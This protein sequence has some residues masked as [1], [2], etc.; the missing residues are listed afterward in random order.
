MPVVAFVVGDSEG[1]G[2]VFGIDDRLHDPRPSG[3]RSATARS[4]IT[5]AIAQLPYLIWTARIIVCSQAFTLP[6]GGYVA[7]HPDLTGIVL[8]IDGERP[9]IGVPAYVAL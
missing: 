3:V 2:S 7:I 4:Q 5:I 6:L 1:M 9:R 8:Y